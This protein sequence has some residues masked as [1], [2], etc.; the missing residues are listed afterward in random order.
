MLGA[1]IK[2]M[3]EM[4]Y[5]L[6]RETPLSRDEIKAIVSLLEH[7]VS[8]K[9]VAE[10]FKTEEWVIKTLSRLCDWQSAAR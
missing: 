10:R 1:Y 8:V 5:H 9:E 4:E 6:K 3:T 7:G 2:T